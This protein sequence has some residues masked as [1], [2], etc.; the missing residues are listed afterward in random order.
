VARYGVEEYFNNELAGQ[1]GKIIGLATPWIGQIG[2]NTVEIEKPQPGMDVY[3]TIDPHIQKELE[4]ILVSYFPAF[5]SD[6][7][8]AIVIE[9]S[10]GKIKAM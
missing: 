10:T 9:P 8:A 2:S 5:R 6:N 3:L 7:I 4:R 1:D